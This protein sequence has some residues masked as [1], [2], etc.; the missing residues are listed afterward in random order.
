MGAGFD[1]PSG[2]M[3]SRKKRLEYSLP[4]QIREIDSVAALADLPF[5]IF[6]SLSLL[7]DPSNTATV[8]L[9]FI[10]PGGLP[11]TTN[12]PASNFVRE[13]PGLYRVTPDLV[14]PKM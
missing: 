2:V 12:P 14:V 11:T 13:L 8:T 10:D 5:S 1:T 7:F 4:Y 3:R 6:T 9:L